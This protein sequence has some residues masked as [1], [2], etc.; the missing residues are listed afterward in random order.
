[1][2]SGGGSSSPQTTTTVQKADPWAGQQPHLTSVMNQA[3]GLSKEPLSYFP[4]QTFAPFSP[5]TNTAL[6]WQTSR[7]VQGSPLTTAGQDELTKTLSGDYLSAGNP[8]FGQM[9]DRITAKVLPG[10]D[11]R[12]AASGRMGSGLHGR[13]VGEGLGDAI[14]SL[15]YQNY[16]DERTN[17]MRGMMFAPQMAQQD[18]FDIAKLA[19]VGGLREDQAQLGINDEMARFDFSQMEPW[20]RLGLYNSL[21]QGNYGGESSSTNSIQLPR[22]SVGAG[23]LGGAASGA[24]MGMMVGGPWG[25]AVGGGLGLLSGLL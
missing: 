17:M 10:I 14:G 11:S 5:E 2:P 22:R 18:Y 7:A 1:M 16:G 9:A 4:G 25:A 3:Q 23:M 20:Q 13:A 8:Y 24:G 19:E 12:F 21:I 6:D 15:A